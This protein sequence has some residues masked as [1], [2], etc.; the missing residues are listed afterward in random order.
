M[1]NQIRNLIVLVLALVVVG[2]FSS[3]SKYRGFKKDDSGFYYK[4]HLE[5]DTA[6]QPKDGDMVLIDFIIRT[7]DTTIN[8]GVTHLPLNESFKFFE[9]DLY[10]ALKTMH[11]GDSVTFIFP[12][13]SFAKYY[14][15]NN[16]PYENKEIYMDV[17]MIDLMTKSEIEAKQ[18][19]Y[20]QK[21]EIAR[22]SEDS[23]RNNYITTNNI[24]T[25][26]SSTGLYYIQTKAGTGKKAEMGKL[27][28]VHYTGK[29]LDGTVFDSSIGKDP[30]TI[31]LGAGQVIPGWEEGIAM[32]KEGGKA[33]LIIPSKL[34]YDSYDAGM[35]P[36]YSTLVF[37]VE[38][39][40]VGDAPQIQPTTVTPGN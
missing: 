7:E 34:A 1:K 10:T 22:V 11:L 35:I 17:K 23:L 24:K 29:L 12:A 28:T 13:D 32:M 38:V 30:I 40:S 18:A 31:Q 8:K 2:A 6:V 9:G 25:K 36:P 39:V 5:N 16:F 33:T 15:N 3:C 20:N 27:V 21:M 26:P 37:D 4:I 14:L 19:E